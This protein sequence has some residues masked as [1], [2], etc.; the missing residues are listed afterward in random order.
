MTSKAIADHMMLLHPE[1]RRLMGEECEA[2][3]AESR[4]MDYWGILDTAIQ[5]HRTQLPEHIPLLLAQLLYEHGARHFSSHADRL[6]PLPCITGSSEAD[7][8]LIQFSKSAIEM[9]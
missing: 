5:R 9:S 3:C 8:V 2:A 1:L 4:A 6:S 7:R